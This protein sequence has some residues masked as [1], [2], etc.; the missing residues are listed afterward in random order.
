MNKF[1]L[2]ILSILIAFLSCDGR[3][4]INKTPREVLL[5]NKLLDSFSENI[6]YFPKEYTE[7]KTDTILSN[8]FRISIKNYSD[9]HH[10]VL[11]TSK[12]ESIINKHYFRKFISEIEVFKDDKPI[13]KQVLNDDF[14]SLQISDYINNEVYIDQVKSLETN[15]VNLVASLCIPRAANCSIYNIVIDA[16]GFY[17]ITKES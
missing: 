11:Q 6:Q 5:E 8:G 2:L 3:D 4:R 16:N 7:V 17:N 13:F 14:L 10:S 15:T 9:M 1:T 12:N